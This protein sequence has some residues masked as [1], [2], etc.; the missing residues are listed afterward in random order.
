MI[1]MIFGLNSSGFAD[2]AMIWLFDQIMN[3]EQIKNPRF[4]EFIKGNRSKIKAGAM[5]YY[6]D[7]DTTKRLNYK[8]ISGIFK[9][10]DKAIQQIRIGPD[11]EIEKLKDTKDGVVKKVIKKLLKR[12]SLT[13]EDEQ[14]L[15]EIID[16]DI[17]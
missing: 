8:R 6:L 7:S 1:L 14:I 5:K 4:R 11:D 17:I 12:E 16:N 2:L 13:L 15:K 9:G 3:P 10:T